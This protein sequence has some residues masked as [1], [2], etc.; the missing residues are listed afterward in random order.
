MAKNS[1]MEA[2]SKR[3][4]LAESV[5]SKSH[6]GEKMSNNTKLVTATCLNNVSKFLNEAFENSTGTQ[7]ADMGLWKKFCLNLVNVAIP[8]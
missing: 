4:A 5:Y 6:E 2:Y 3:L 7:R 8:Y 1:L